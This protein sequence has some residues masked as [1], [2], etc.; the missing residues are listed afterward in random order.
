MKLE[1]LIKE[2]ATAIY[3]AALAKIKGLI[4]AEAQ[5]MG[6]NSK[7]GLQMFTASLVAK[8]NQVPELAHEVIVRN[9]VGA[10]VLD[11]QKRM[12]A[13]S[14]AGETKLTPGEE[15]VESGLLDDVLAESEQPDAPV[16]STLYTAESLDALELKDVKA[17][18]FDLGL[19]VGTRK[20]TNI[21]RILEQ[22]AKDKALADAD[23]HT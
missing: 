17:I 23:E 6:I 19:E 3:G 11:E 18:C 13:A 8:T 12:S 21:K 10:I 9:I 16:E 4:E 20:D 14:E 22:Q 1:D 2:R 7:D 15:L 5:A